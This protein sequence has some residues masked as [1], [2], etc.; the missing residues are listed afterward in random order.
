MFDVTYVI[1]QR[2]DDYDP[3]NIDKIVTTIPN[4]VA[5]LIEAELNVEILLI[6]WCS[7]VPLHEEKKIQD[8]PLPITHL[9]IEP[10]LILADNLNPYTFLEYFAKNIGIRHAQGE[11]VLIE[12]SDTLNSKELGEEIVKMVKNEISGAYGRPIER[13]N[14]LFPSLEETHRD[15]IWDKPFGDLNPGDFLMARKAEFI[16]CA[17]GYDETNTVHRNGFPQMHMDVEILIQMARKGM[18]CYFLQGNYM[19][20]HH[21]KGFRVYQSVRNGSGYKNRPNWGYANTIKEYIKPNV[22]KLLRTS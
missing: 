17:E 4:N 12:N 22:F 21:E 14:V 7:E 20:L 3:D 19:H 6:D 2:N 16:N 11:Y 8:I 1:P 5:P 9:V 13:I 18:A 10:D 15:Q